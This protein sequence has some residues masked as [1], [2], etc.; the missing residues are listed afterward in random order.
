MSGLMSLGANWVFLVLPMVCGQFPGK[1]DPTVIALHKEVEAIENGLRVSYGII[2]DDKW[3]KLEQALALG[4]IL[5]GQPKEKLQ[6]TFEEAKASHLVLAVDLEMV[7]ERSSFSAFL[8][9]GTKK[10]NQIFFQS[11]AK[12]DVFHGMALLQSRLSESRGMVMTRLILQYDLL[13][14]FSKL[15][16]AKGTEILGV[17]FIDKDAKTN[18]AKWCQFAEKDLAAVDLESLLSPMHE[19]M[20]FPR[21]PYHVIAACYHMALKNTKGPS[22]EVLLLEQ[23]DRLQRKLDRATKERASIEVIVQLRYEWE[24]CQRLLKEKVLSTNPILPDKDNPV[25]NRPR[26]PIFGPFTSLGGW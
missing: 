25:I 11:P 16:N 9:N 18:Q 19:K 21:D 1:T 12:R 24:T 14:P 8:A 15:G 26:Q 13:V 2:C 6:K 22:Q 17:E 10:D 20:N 5:K 3:I 23:V 7:Q 4:H